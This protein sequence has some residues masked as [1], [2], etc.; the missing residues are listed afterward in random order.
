LTSIGTG[1]TL[2]KRTKFFYKN[3]SVSNRKKAKLTRKT[4]PNPQFW[5]KSTKNTHKNTKN[6]MKKKPQKQNN[7]RAQLCRK[8]K[9]KNPT[10]NPNK[11]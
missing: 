8:K 6:Q 1:K 9:T 4:K 2:S 7:H 5:N 3:S 11:L 10:T